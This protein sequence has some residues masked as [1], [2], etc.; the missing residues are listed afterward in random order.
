MNLEKLL[1][2]IDENWRLNSITFVQTGDASQEFL[3]Y[4]DNDHGA[5]AAVEE[6]FTAQAQVFE[7][8]AI[9]EEWHNCAED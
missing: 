3:A 6:A 9:G 4:L 1:T 7:G 5:Q 8:G 2:N